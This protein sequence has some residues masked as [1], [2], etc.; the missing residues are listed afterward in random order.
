[1]KRTLTIPGPYNFKQALIRLSM[2][3]LLQIDL[4]KQMMTVPLW[5]NESPITVQLQQIGTVDT[6]EF[7]I[8][9]PREAAEEQVIKQLSHLFHWNINLGEVAVHF[10]DTELDSIFKRFRGLPF[11]SD[12]QLYGSLMKQLSI[13][14]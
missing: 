3:P 4:K 6:P 9:F 10:E 2:D 5:L 13:S 12:S 14:S 1:M 11:V 7:I 8:T